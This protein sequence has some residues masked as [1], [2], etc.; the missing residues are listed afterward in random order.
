MFKILQKADDEAFGK[1]KE[2][3]KKEKKR[4]KVKLNGY[5]PSV[6]DSSGAEKQKENV[7]NMKK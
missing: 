3:K 2:R 7:M 4:K 5:L 1:K 6:V